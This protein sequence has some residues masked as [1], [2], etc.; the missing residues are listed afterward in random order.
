MK[1]VVR[2]SLERVLAVPEQERPRILETLPPEIREEILELLHFDSQAGSRVIDLMIANAA[3]GFVADQLTEM[4]V[5]PGMHLGPY[6]LEEAV[7]AG[8]DTVGPATS[9]VTGANFAALGSQTLPSA[10]EPRAPY[11]RALRAT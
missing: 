7:G 10:C 4:R 9:V 1:P 11:R 5:M 6:R 3:R 2:K 8:G